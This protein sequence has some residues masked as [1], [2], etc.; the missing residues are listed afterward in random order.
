MPKAIPQLEEE[1]RPECRTLGDPGWNKRKEPVPG[2]GLVGLGWQLYGS[3]KSLRRVRAHPSSND[4]C[5]N[6]GFVLSRGTGP[7]A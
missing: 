6:E 3:C 1:Q 7:W 5:L 4:P 2:L